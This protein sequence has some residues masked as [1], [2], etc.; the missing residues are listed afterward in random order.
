MRDDAGSC[1]TA[2][3]EWSRVLRHG[4]RGVAALGRPVGPR[5]RLSRWAWSADAI[6]ALSVA[7]VIAARSGETV[8]S[9]DVEAAAG[10]YVG[11]GSAHS[12]GLLIAVLTALPLVVRR[13]Y[14]LAA[15]W[16][17]MVA[18]QIGHHVAGFDPVLTVLACVIAAYRAALYSPYQVVAIISALAGSVVLVAAYRANLPSV[19]PGLLMVA[20][21]VPVG[22]AANTI[23]SWKQQVR[24]LQ[25][26]QEAATR[27]AVQQERSRIAQDLHDVVTHSVSVMVVQAGAARSVLDTQPELTREALL[28]VESGGRAAMTELRHVMGLLTMGEDDPSR[29]GHGLDVAEP[30]TGDLAPQPGL[31]QVPDMVAR[32]Q[33]TGL[34]V[35]LVISGPPV[36]L[37]AGVDVAAYRVIQEGLTNTLKHAV[38]ARVRIEV[39]YLPDTLRVRITDSGGGSRAST[40]AGSGRGLVGLRERLAIYGGTLETGHLPDGGYHVSAVIPTDPP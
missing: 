16:L 20:F 26:Q 13:R 40:A 19:R 24:A 5:P 25:S 2:G 21:L 28:A 1:D 27:R 18:A 34:S 35:D 9:S 38:G 12:W 17:T 32:V 31:L 10:V 14:P 3:V 7:L 4:R 22:L 15:F 36:E 11:H 33:D 30:T 8:S 6:L 29:D 37:P 39:A 23:H